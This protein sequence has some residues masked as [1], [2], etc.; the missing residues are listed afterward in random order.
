[1]G[2]RV[3]Q[4][5]G[6]TGGEHLAAG[7]VTLLQHAVGQCPTEAAD[8]RFAFQ[9][10]AIKQDQ[11]RHGDAPYRRLVEVTPAGFEAWAAGMAEPSCGVTGK[12]ALI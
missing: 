6:A 11:M 1:M 5:A 3:G 2:R 9:V 4:H 7:L 12:M 10:G 8:V